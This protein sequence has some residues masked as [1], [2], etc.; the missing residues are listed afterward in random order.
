MSFTF[1]HRCALW[2][3]NGDFI[4]SLPRASPGRKMGEDAD[5]A[6]QGG[7][8]PICAALSV[9]DFESENTVSCQPL[10]PAGQG[11]QG[12]NSGPLCVAAYGPHPCQPHV[13]A[14]QRALVPWELYSSSGRSRNPVM[15]RWKN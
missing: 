6:P 11:S 2:L 15:E 5:L 3:G 10:W 8:H 12:S 14:Q 13:W 9:R 4:H 1:T 7:H